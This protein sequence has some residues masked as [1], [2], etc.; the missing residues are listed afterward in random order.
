MTIKTICTS[1]ID[2]ETRELKV[3]Y[4][5]AC[6]FADTDESAIVKYVQSNQ[7]IHVTLENIE[8]LEY[9]D[10]YGETCKFYR[11]HFHSDVTPKSH[12]QDYLVVN[13]K[14]INS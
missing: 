1:Y 13:A 8:I 11:V 6:V 14:F 3:L 7:N 4:P 12:H 10:A 9:T 5:Q 2:K